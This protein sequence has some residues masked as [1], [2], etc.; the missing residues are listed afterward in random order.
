MHLRIPVHPCSGPYAYLLQLARVLGGTAGDHPYLGTS[1]LEE[2]IL[3]HR[4]SEDPSQGWVGFPLSH[5]WAFALGW[6]L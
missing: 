5:P 2:K 1:Q 4:H 3:K 6:I